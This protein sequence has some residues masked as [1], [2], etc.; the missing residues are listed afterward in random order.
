MAPYNVKKFS[1]YLL[2]S[3]IILSIKINSFWN[4]GVS[5]IIV[6]ILSTNIFLSS[7]SPKMRKISYNFSTELESYKNLN[8]FHEV[9]IP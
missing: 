1:K 8:C 2:P 9:E 3:S 6:K 7:V 4:L 5:C